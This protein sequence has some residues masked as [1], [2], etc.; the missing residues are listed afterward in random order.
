MKA[1]LG[2]EV[3]DA[4]RIFVLADDS[5]SDKRHADACTIAAVVQIR[6]ILRG[7]SREGQI[8]IIPEIQD[9]RSKFLL[10][11]CGIRRFIDAAGMPVQV[12]AAVSMNPRL[13]SVM[14][15]LLG[16]HALAEG[17]E[18]IEDAG[19]VGFVIHKLEDYLPDGQ[20]EPDKISFMEAQAL[21]SAAGDALIGWTIDHGES[22]EGL[23]D[24]HSPSTRL[25]EATRS[26][27]SISVTTSN[28]KRQISLT[29]DYHLTAAKDLAVKL[30][31][32]G[33]RFCFGW[34]TNPRDKTTERDWSPKH[35][36]CVIGYRENA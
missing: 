15:T 13:L 20:P 24:I 28:K 17:E 14:R 2:I 18:M 35:R 34:E 23:D 31:G 19:A 25:E 10:K 5:H 11:L 16:G 22:L 7:K 6:E 9:T 3:E 12:V 8:P 33:D 1:N 32:Q 29:T 26:H 36:L 4:S 21:A 30:H 27:S